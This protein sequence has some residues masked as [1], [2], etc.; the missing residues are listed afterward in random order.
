MLC[1]HHLRNKEQLYFTDEKLLLNFSLREQQHYNFIIIMI[2]ILIIMV[3]L[4]NTVN[5][6]LTWLECAKG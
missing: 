2:I 3:I 6:S 4:S 5:L 1:P